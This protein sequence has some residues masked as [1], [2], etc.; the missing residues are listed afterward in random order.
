M[1][2]TSGEEDKMVRDLAA[3]MGITLQP[4]IDYLKRHKKAAELLRAGS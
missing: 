3:A 4:V 1:G 2:W